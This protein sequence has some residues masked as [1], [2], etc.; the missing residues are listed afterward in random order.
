MNINEQMHELGTMGG[1]AY[2]PTDDTISSLLSKT[3][4]VRVARQSAASL[5]GTVGA[6]AIGLA[7]MQAYGAA[8]DDPAFRDRNVIND[9]D[10]LTSIELYRAKFGNDNPTRNYESAV[11]LSVII[12]KLKASAAAGGSQPVAPVAP[13]APAPAAPAPAAPAAKA[14][15]P[16]AP[17]TTSPPADPYAQCKADHP[18]KPYKSYDCAAN[19]WVIKPGWFKDPADSQYYQCSAQPAYVGYTY[20]CATGKYA[21]KAG[22]FWFGNGNVYQ[23]ITWVDAATGVSSLGNW[24]GSGNWGGWDLKAIQLDSGSKTYREYVYMGSNATWAGTTCAGVAAVKYDANVHAS[25]LPESKVAATGKT[26][27]MKDGVAW[28]LDNQSLKWHS[29]LNRF[30][31]PANPPNG[32]TWD[33]SSWVEVPPTT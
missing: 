11:D 19:Q 20:D 8:K 13:V 24:S 12:A 3:K 10:G 25:C 15:A 33:G 17:A 5:A 1:L 14:P 22:Y 31:D 18:D 30:A 21:P 28:V 6:L 27:A 7:A 4:R 32:W 26:Y 29:G 2:A 16:A 23:A 9:K